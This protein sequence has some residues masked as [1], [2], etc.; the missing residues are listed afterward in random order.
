MPDA[1]DIGEALRAAA[2]VENVLVRAA[3]LLAMD[4][5]YAHDR[6]LE[7]LVAARAQVDLIRDA[8]AGRS[9]A[10]LDPRD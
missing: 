2:E 6:A 5:P 7:I 10:S 3:A 8:L 1:H 9:I 4:D